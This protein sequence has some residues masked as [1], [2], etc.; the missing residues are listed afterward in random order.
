M[1]TGSMRAGLLADSFG[2]L[3]VNPN[4]VFGFF[5][6]ESKQFALRTIQF[7][8]CVVGLLL[9]MKVNARCFLKL[10]LSL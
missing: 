3:N 6:S 5:G 4:F 7:K 2:Q 9:T 10:S 8:A 1:L